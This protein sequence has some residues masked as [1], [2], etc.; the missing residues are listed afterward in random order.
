MS[1]LIPITI[2]S[3]VMAMLSHRFSEYDYINYKYVR[4]ERFFYTIMS[5]AMILFVGL[6][7]YFNDTYLYMAIYEKTPKDIGL[8]DGIDWSKLGENPGYFF[9]NRVIKRLGFTVHGYLIF[10]AIISVGIPLWFI[11]KYS[12]DITLSIWIFICFAGYL[13]TLAALK[14]CVAMA[15]CMLATHYVIQKKYIPFILWVLVAMT[16][17]PYALLYFAT[18]F[19]MFRPW[20]GKTFAM[21]V[22]AVCV[23]FSLKTIMGTL[24]SMT[25]MLGEHYDK[26]SFTGEG[27]NPMRLVVTSVPVVLSLVV[28]RQISEKD[29][30]PHYLIVNLSMLNAELMFVALFGDPNYF[31]RLANYFLPFQALS[32]PWLLTHFTPNSKRVMTILTAV[33]FG[34]YLFYSQVIHES[35]DDCYRGI[36]LWKYFEILLTGGK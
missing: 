15:L 1:K 19:L 18:P 34:G 30:T 27:I 8:M 25:D 9:M 35:F 12:S 16:Y 14:Q 7:T 4:R 22:L 11:R 31:G 32:I 28:S 36:S 3:I 13:F 2:F 33:G 29:D 23:G 6:R 20:G 24:I 10:H 26:E 17:H 5:I 21:L